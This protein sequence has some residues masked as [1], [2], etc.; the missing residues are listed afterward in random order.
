MIE[1]FVNHWYFN[2]KYAGIAEMLETVQNIG[3]SK[4]FFYPFVGVQLFS[5]TGLNFLHENL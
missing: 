5:E 2:K 4:V 1:N 3:I